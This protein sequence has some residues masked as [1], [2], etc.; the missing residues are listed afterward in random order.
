[1]QHHFYS[2]SLSHTKVPLLPHQRLI[3]S[4]FI[5]DKLREEL[6]QRNEAQWMT[7]NDQS[8][9]AEVHVYHSLYPLEQEKLGNYNGYPATVYKATCSIDRRSYALVRIEGY[10][11]VNESAVSIAEVWRNVRHCNI[12]SFREGFT[13]K[14]FGDDCKKGK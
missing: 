7:S 9:P 14:A 10:S 13:T 3:N 2:S 11:N 1:M 4:F 8:L 5:P 12:V 6:T